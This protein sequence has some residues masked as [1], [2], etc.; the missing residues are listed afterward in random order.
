MQ[1]LPVLLPQPPVG[2][3]QTHAKVVP[4]APHTSP[5]A[6]Q[7]VSASCR[8]VCVSAV[9]ATSVLLWQ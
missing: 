8:Q 2:A 3:G 1:A 6:A 5:E 7:L 9:Q 4:D